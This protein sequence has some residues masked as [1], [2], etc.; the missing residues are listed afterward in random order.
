MTPFQDSNS[1][2]L[3]FINTKQGE[4][5]LTLFYKIFSQNGILYFFNAQA[6]TTSLDTGVERGFSNTGVSVQFPS[7]T[8]LISF[9]CYRDY[10]ECLPVHMIYPFPLQEGSDVHFLH[11]CS[12]ISISIQGFSFFSAAIFIPL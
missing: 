10:F 11:I 5:L 8:T 1:E 9:F 2:L 7:T 4:V 3:C 6:S 12:M